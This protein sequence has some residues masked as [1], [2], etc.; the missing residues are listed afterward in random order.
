M[1][2]LCGG[3][4]GWRK[5]SSRGGECS[6]FLASSISLLPQSLFKD[7]CMYNVCIICRT[8][9]YFYFQ[10]L[11]NSKLPIDVLGRVWDL[12]DIDRDGMLDSDEFAVVS[13]E[14]FN[15][16]YILIKEYEMAVHA[17]VM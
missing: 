6:H 9:D 5:E 8:V 15:D 4:G 7:L 13:G 12:S 17:F 14:N 11:L 1:N 3:R 2:R 16:G 10:V